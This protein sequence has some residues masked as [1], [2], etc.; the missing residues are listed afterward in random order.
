[1]PE[2]IEENKD[3]NK[4]ISREQYRKYWIQ[5]SVVILAA[6]III[7]FYFCVK[8]YDGL[9]EALST[10]NTIL[11]PIIVGF[12]L[13]FLL[14]PIMK[15]LENS[16]LP[17]F[18][19]RTK[20]EKK[21]RKRVRN[22]SSLISLLIFIAVII[23]F[24]WAVIPQIVSTI[25]DLINNIDS[26]IIGVIDWVD[27]LTNGYFAEE[28]K[29]A[30]NTKNIENALST[31]LNYVRDYLN[32]GST[33]NIVKTLTNLG[34]N[35]G[36]G[37]LNAFL[38]IIISVYV[39]NSK[40]V[41]KGHTKKLV[42]GIFKPSHA[43]VVLDIGRKAKEVFYGFIA[44]KII[45]SVIIGVLCYFLML[46]FRFPYPTLCSF[47]IGLTNVIPVFGP[48]IGAI[49]TV[50]LVF[51]NN[52]VMGIYFLIFVIVLQQVDGNI[53]GPAILGNST[54]LSPFWV[55]FAI[56][57]GGGLFGVL[58]MFLG[59]PIVALLYYI[60]GKIANWAVTKHGLS[61]ESVNYV[62][63]KAVD[64]DT[65]ELIQK[66][67]DELRNNDPMKK[68]INISKIKK[69]FKKKEKK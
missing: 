2:Q 69:L 53:I 3:K 50:P 19:K 56:V 11:S 17:F 61:T 18:L 29:Q 67:D 12:V 54:G 51:M 1:M 48:Y 6:F 57:V 20:D 24:L 36:K 13:A 9:R 25:N 39:L 34:I 47:I 27:D 33:D 65:H 60:G 62:N 44:G 35:V 16:L 63:M 52:P 42:C 68:A 28:L 4:K 32:L 66:S 41:F 7:I 14:N 64:K 8:R 58:G 15:A 46:L 5:A 45:D 40:E 38:G 30:R 43:N 21:T 31:A 26:Q 22:S 49:F 37:I 59:V 55:V 10:L 23:I